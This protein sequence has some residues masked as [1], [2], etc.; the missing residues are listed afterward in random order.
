M[1]HNGSRCSW[2]RERCVQRKE[3]W[4]REASQ[5]GTCFVLI[6][7]M[8]TTNAQADESPPK[9]TLAAIV[10]DVKLAKT[11]FSATP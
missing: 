8:N 2:K 9:S 5:Q 7:K 1:T 6:L 4:R 3:S 10:A 11:E